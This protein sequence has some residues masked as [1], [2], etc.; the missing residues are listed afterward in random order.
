VDN[1]LLLVLGNFIKD[2]QTDNDRKF[3]RFF[4]TSSNTNTSSLRGMLIDSLMPQSY[5]ASAENSMRAV[6]IHSYTRTADTIADLIKKNIKNLSIDIIADEKKQAL[7]A[8][9]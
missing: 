4:G 5:F 9:K 7:P 2:G 1:K 3:L 8:R 6:N